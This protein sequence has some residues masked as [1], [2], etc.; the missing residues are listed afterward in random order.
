MKIT[1]KKFAAVEALI[2]QLHSEI[3]RNAQGDNG[4]D[5]RNR[6]EHYRVKLEGLLKGKQ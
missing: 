3:T 6:R 4:Q 1:T 2:K 5:V